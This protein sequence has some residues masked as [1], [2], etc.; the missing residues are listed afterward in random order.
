MPSISS[1][2]VVPIGDTLLIE[3]AQNF[4]ANIR[5]KTQKLL[6]VLFHHYPQ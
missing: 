1:V 6:E 4:R 2:K 5:I 3:S